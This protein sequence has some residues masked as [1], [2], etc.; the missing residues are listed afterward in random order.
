MSG[1]NDPE[2]RVAIVQMNAELRH[3]QLE[4]LS[5]QCATDRVRLRFSLEEVARHAHTDTLRKALGTV[6]ALHRY[7]SSIEELRASVTPSA[8]EDGR[9]S[10]KLILEANRRVAA[11]LQ[12]QRE[13]YFAQGKP[14][15]RE[16]RDSM[17]RFFPS[18]LLAGVRTV[19][20]AGRR[21]P[22]PPFYAEARAMGFGNLPEMTHMASLTF[23]D[24]VVFNETITERALFHGLVH[25]VQFQV[26]G[27]ERYTNVFVRG[28][29]NH[30][31]HYNVP[32][33]AQAIALEEKYAAGV[34]FSVEEQVWLWL[35]QGRYSLP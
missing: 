22:N 34:S 21:I 32:L 28:F 11:Y 6:T 14:L 30:K 25:A 13:S 5:A 15:A 16:H 19:E 4:L 1:S 27:L 12:S 2:N 20:M 10:P 17:E 29:L 26:L 35:N 23:I 3:A 18:R 9:V 33:E 8:V 7:Y 31:R 24:V